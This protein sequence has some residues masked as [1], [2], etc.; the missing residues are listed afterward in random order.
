LEGSVARNLDFEI[1]H[2]SP[3]GSWRPNWTW[4]GTYAETWPIAEQEWS[5][6]LTLQTLQTLRAFV[7]LEP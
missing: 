4:Y 5:G 6:V 7:R 2:Q 1:E 3:D